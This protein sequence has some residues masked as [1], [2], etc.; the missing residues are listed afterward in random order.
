MNPWGANN[1]TGNATG[2]ADGSSNN[3]AFNPTSLDQSS[4]AG[5]ATIDPSV[6]F[7]NPSPL[8]Q[9][10]MTPAQQL[11]AQQRMFN[12]GLGPG[13]PN[14]RNMSPGF[15][16]PGSVIPS[17]RPRPEDSMGMSGG[18]NMAGMPGGM[19]PN[20][21]MMMS[22]RPPN[23]G[24]PSLQFPSAGNAGGQHGQMQDFRKFTTFTSANTIRTSSDHDI[25]KR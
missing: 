19:P 14:A 6:A 5:A 21:G 7:F 2:H 4:G 8:P 12:G 23:M 11:Q 1:V 18:M 16:A 20:M 13:G 24:S 17:K 9:H 15:H 22:P 10:N 3:G 25:R